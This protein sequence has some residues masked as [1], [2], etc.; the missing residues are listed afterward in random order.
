MPDRWSAAQIEAL[1]PDSSSQK[2]ARKLADPGPWSDIGVADGE[3]PL[4]WGLCRG[5]GSKPYQA[6]VDLA[7]PAYRCSCPSRKFPCKHALA[8]LLLWSD[9]RVPDGE[10]LDWVAEWRDGRSARKEK[11]EKKAAAPVDPEAARKR[12][13][14]RADRI[15]GGLA[16]LD[17]WLTDQ[18][19]QGLAEGG[20][21]RYDAVRETAARLVDA[22][23]GTA[24]NTVRRL[25][26]I[27]GPDGPERLLAELSLLRLLTSAYGRIDTLPPELAATVRSR[28]GV[29]VGTA[30]VLAGPAV[31]DRWLVL[32][33]RDETDEKVTTRRTWLRGHGSGRPALVLAFSAPGQSLPAD[34]VAGGTIDADL[35]FYPGAQP[36]RALVGERRGTEV[37]AAPPAGDDIPAAL[38]A[39]AAAL[40]ADP[41]LDGW[42]MLLADAAYT[43][44]GGRWLVVTP[45]GTGLPVHP[46]AGAPWP[47]VAR[48]GGRPG[49]VAAEWSPRGLWPLN[50]FPAQEPADA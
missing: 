19:R 11:A 45:D 26:S 9:G 38:A 22:Q 41:W 25:A 40:A 28:A 2:A 29:P 3:P 50:L 18:V 7:E 30:E 13:E 36:L 4:L 21:S 43:R 12:A 20:A 14:K 1:A 46:R 31:P 6:C 39:H 49:T 47:E 34:L 8:L 32:G 15:S 37:A 17:R 10:P 24:A 33:H 23:A 5:S 27:V 16:E 48:C 35:H 44:H 42:P